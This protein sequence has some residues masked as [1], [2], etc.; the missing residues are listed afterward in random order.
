MPLFWASIVT[1][2]L[3]L[4]S[5]WIYVSYVDFYCLALL[6]VGGIV[7]SSVVS[8]NEGVLSSSIIVLGLSVLGLMIYSRSN[9][10]ARGDDSSGVSQL[11]EI[12]ESVQMSENAKRVLFRDREL[13]LLRRTVQEDLTRGEFHSALVLCDQ[14]AN[15]FGAV[16][17]AEELRTKV[18]DTIHEQHEHRIKNEIGQ[19]NALLEV[20]KWV[21]AYQLAS[22]LRRLFP[23]SPLL[24]GI[25]QKIA[26]VRME[27]RHGLEERFLVAAKQENVELSMNLLRELDGYL[28]PDEA[29]KFRDTATAVITT[30][31]ESLSA[32]FKMAVSDH[33]WQ[34]A[35]EFGIEIT[36]Q[37]PNTKMAEEV[38]SMLETI[39]VRADEDETTI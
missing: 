17:E 34:E 6:S 15:V 10:A 25:E 36:K 14:M 4:V 20:H 18:Q 35:I 23:E 5:F 22:K 1:I 13:N 16:E 12:L 24:H 27:Y 2:G 21:E 26:D 29:R 11:D 33:R 38:Q 32:R 8:D 3:I 7:S 9:Y 28:T 37:F 30:Y 31:R 39:R 19:L